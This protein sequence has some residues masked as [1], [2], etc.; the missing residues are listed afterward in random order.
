[1][2]RHFNEEQK[3][4]SFEKQNELLVTKL[5]ELQERKFHGRVTLELCAGNITQAYIRES[6][7]LQEEADGIPE[8]QAQ[9][10]GVEAQ[11]AAARP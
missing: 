8:K 6:W 7:K 11:A 3:A 2:S 9:A 10:D 1:M 5:E 4:R